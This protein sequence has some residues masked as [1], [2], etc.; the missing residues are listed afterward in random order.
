MLAG[1]GHR[2]IGRGHN[3][4]RAIHLGGTRD[5]VL[6]VIGVAGAINMRVVTGF[7]L[8]LNMRR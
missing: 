2:P 3:K 6:D 4:D 8:I 1:L 7:R 5:H